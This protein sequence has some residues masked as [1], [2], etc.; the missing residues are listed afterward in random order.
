MCFL[1]LD[2]F[3]YLLLWRH[4]AVSS[5][6]RTML[7]VREVW[8]SNPGSVKLDTVSPTAC[9]CGDVSSNCVGAMPRR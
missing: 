9:H 6:V 1:H 8:G 7:T 4:R 3:Y 5:V 2:L